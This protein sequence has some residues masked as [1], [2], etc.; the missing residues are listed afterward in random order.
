MS[1]S[2]VRKNFNIFVDGRGYAGQATEF[3]APKLSLKMEEFR[4]GGMDGT[5]EIPVGME[6]MNSDFA[7]VKYD[8]DVIALF[9][10]TKGAEKSITVYETLESFDG[11][12]T[13][14]VHSMTGRITELDPGASKP[15]TIPELKASLA[16]SYYKLTHGTTIVHEIDVPNMVRTINGVDQLA[17]QRKNLGM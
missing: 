13:P 17:E 1:A 14:I 7:L 11:S 6:K 5:V 15:G 3:N 16:L 12:A 8:A 10:I 2:D 4:G 9:G